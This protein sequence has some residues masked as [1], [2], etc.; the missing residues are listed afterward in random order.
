[1]TT[2]ICHCPLCGTISHVTCDENAYDRYVTTRTPIQEIF[3]DMTIQNRELLISGMCLACQG[4]FFEESDD[5]C[6]FDG[7]CENCPYEVCPN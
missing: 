1:M 2:V 4:R 6:D 7:D 3:P 5:D